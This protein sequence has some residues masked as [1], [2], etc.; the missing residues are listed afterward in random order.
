[1]SRE[2]PYASIVRQYIPAVAIFVG[3]FVS[4]LVIN[5]AVGGPEG[6][7]RA[8]L[9]G[10]AGSVIGVTIAGVVIVRPYE[11]RMIE[12]RR[13][14][15]REERLYRIGASR[16]EFETNLGIA[17][18]MT[19]TE[20]D[21]LEL[22]ERALRTA[23]PD[24]WAEVL[25]ADKGTEDLRRV[26][27]CSVDGEPPMCSVESPDRCPAAR[28]SRT[29]TFS[30][31]DSIDACPRLADRPQGRCS[32][33]CVPLSIMGQTV[34]VV[35][36]TGEPGSSIDDRVTEDLETLALHLGQ[37]LGM[38]R[39]MAE[40]QLEASTDG[41]TGL[42]N[43]RSLESRIRVLRNQGTPFVFAMADLDHF[44]RLNDTHGHEA[45][46]RALRLF[47]NVLRR[48]VRPVDLVCRYGGEEFAIVLAESTLDEATRTMERLREHLALALHRGSVPRFTVSIG[49]A[50]Q[51]PDED[52]ADLARRADTALYA[53]KDAGRNRVVAA[54]IAGLEVEDTAI[55]EA[56]V[57]DSGRGDGAV[58]GT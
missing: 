19:E 56:E 35:H 34:G 1:M 36:V 7:A 26:A 33:T 23:A 22:A 5:E 16:R 50:E 8:L 11:V 54:P 14:A 51:G 30:D 3:S 6:I 18:E 53:A 24:T 47:A 44:K 10:V 45:G 48:S 25:A 4:V 9:V 32:A 31:S 38:L 39:V 58:L 29:L 15:A 28:N 37:R 12:R 40:T 41:L 46:D 17:L 27:V 57:A 42:L 49:L 55:A 43:R 20:E 13:R 2:S 52:L 21:A